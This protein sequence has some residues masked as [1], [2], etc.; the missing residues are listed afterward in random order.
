MFSPEDIQKA[1]ANK[2]RESILEISKDLKTSL[3]E[4]GRAKIREDI[5]VNV[6]LPFFA[7]EE[8]KYKV[9]LGNWET[10]ASNGGLPGGLYREVEVVNDE[11]E[12]LFS[13]PPIYDRDGIKP[14]KLSDRI[15]L[16]GLFEQAK[17]LALIKPNLAVNQQNS[18]FSHLLTKM[19]NATDKTAEYIKRWNDIFLRYGRD[20]SIVK[21]KNNSTGQSSDSQD[22]SGYEIE[23]L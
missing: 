13:V 6:F 3:E 9:G 16:E 21:D 4:E 14:V 23:E 2:Q 10:V 22:G 17:L 11:N 8:N 15:S 7:G 5:F 12:V 18:I 1:I 20:S 19:T